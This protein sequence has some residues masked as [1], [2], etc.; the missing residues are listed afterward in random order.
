MAVILLVR[1]GQASFGAKDYDALSERGL[2]QA[3][4]LGSALKERLPALDAV[5]TGTMRRHRQTAEACLASL[6]H[7]PAPRAL[8]GF[9]EFDH[10]EVLA[11]H[12][13]R[14][15]DPTVMGAELMGTAD[16]RRAFQ[17]L[18]THAVA[19][20]VSGAHDSDYRES[21]AAF[22]ARSLA[23]LDE[24]V[25]ALGPARTVLVFTSGGV[26]SAIVQSLLQLPDASAF[27]VNWALANC[28]L[29]KV[30]CGSSGRHLST[31][32]EHAHF[33]RPEHRAL[34]TYR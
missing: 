30:V 14:Y 20:W 23:A 9:D 10:Q 21:W 34:L 12:T 24:A 11:R 13:A 25:G 19:R 32:N 4:V 28:G 6:P 2:E 22:R 18:F 15:A 26:I 27:R 31:L 16:P 33:E 29:T 17:E 5:L 3:R 7:A 1:H 8:A